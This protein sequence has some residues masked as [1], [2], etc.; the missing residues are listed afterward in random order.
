M[1]RSVTSK[2]GGFK[3]ADYNIILKWLG[4]SEKIAEQWAE[5]IVLMIGLIASLLAYV[6]TKK[7]MLRIL[8]HYIKNNKY[9]FDDIMLE[10]KVFSRLSQLIPAVVLYSFSK[11][12]PS[13]NPFLDKLISLYIIVIIVMVLD[14]ILNSFEAIYNTHSVSKA[15][16]I[17]GYLQVIKIF[18]YIMAAIVLIA[19]IIG[20]SP[21]YLLSGIGAMTAVIMLIF[22]NSILGL[23]AGIQLTANDML[24]IGDW[25]E[26]PKYD[27]NGD[28]LEIALT[29]VKVENFDRTITTIPTHA[30]IN[31][32]FKN[33]RGMSKSGGRRIKRA[34]YLDQ[35]SIKFCTNEMLERFKKIGYIADYIDEKNA[36]IETYNNSIGTD[37][38]L[39][40]NGRHLTNVGVFRA[41]VQR[42][43]ENHPKIH[44]EM[45]IM[46]RQLAPD[47]TGLPIEVYAFTNDIAWKNYEMIQ[48]DIFDHLISVVPIFDLK[49]YQNPTEWGN[50]IEQMEQQI[51]KNT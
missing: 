44:K 2:K 32:S 24:R 37:T 28:V 47:V 38:T 29:T 9:K 20:K 45:I 17:K 23:V 16:P 42:Y 27:A 34:V 15:R 40:V 5:P 25:I 30:L 49:V 46:S 36:E 48:G 18:I 22:Q 35:R 51:E 1:V 13:F 43:L 11:L 6:L 31:D 19:N 41:Y 21:I 8:N 3:M 26:M 10:K 39:K 7:V 4:L 12:L 14:A 33:W 50:S